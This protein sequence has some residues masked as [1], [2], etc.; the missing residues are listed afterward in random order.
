MYQEVNCSLCHTL[1]SELSASSPECL[2]EPCLAQQITDL[3]SSNQSLL[4]QTDF[5]SRQ[6]QNFKAEV[7]SLARRG[8]STDPG[9]L[10]QKTRE[11]DTLDTLLVTNA[12]KAQQ[13]IVSV[14]GL[15][16]SEAAYM[17]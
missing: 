9:S 8:R 2:C 3:T 4:D 6:L 17:Q 11:K 13:L 1:L 14:S 16:K 5:Y 15:E 10:A 12:E 7:D